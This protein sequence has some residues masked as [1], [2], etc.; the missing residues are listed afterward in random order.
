MTKESMSKESKTRVA[1]VLGLATTLFMLPVALEKSNSNHES[2]SLKPKT[3]SRCLASD[4][5]VCNNQEKIDSLK[6]DLENLE[7]QKKKILSS[8][9]KI[10]EEEKKSEDIEETVDVNNQEQYLAYMYSMMNAQASQNENAIWSLYS[11]MGR[12]MGQVDPIGRPTSQS[13]YEY[14][15]MVQLQRWSFSMDEENSWHPEFNNRGDLTNPL[16]GNPGTWD[17]VRSMYR[18]PT[19]EFMFSY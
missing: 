1:K 18:N 14:L 6:A 4:S 11:E 3:P 5:V 17:S 10:E 9:E 13:R 2:F 7:E 8:I 19:S 12:N 15:Q 16:Y